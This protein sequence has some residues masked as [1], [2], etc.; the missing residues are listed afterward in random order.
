MTSHTFF[1]VLTYVLAIPIDIESAGICG[2]GICAFRALAKSFVHVMICNEMTMES[3][4]R[5]EKGRQ[6]SMGKTI[7]L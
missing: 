3:V 2:K 4:M 5:S 7:T 6:E 1:L